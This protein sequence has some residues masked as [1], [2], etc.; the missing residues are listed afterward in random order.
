MPVVRLCA[1]QQFAWLRIFWKGRRSFM[2]TIYICQAFVRGRGKSLKAETPIS[3]GTPEEA[4]RRAERLASVGRLGAV[5]Y[6]V[7]IDE[8]FGECDDPPNV[9]YRH[10]EVPEEF[11]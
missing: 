7:Q 1:N 8:V 9:F 6:S 5:G 4:I 10:G 11:Q 2:K 3:C